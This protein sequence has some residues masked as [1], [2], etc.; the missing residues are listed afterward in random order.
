[1]NEE[2]LFTKQR[3]ESE[4]RRRIESKLDLAKLLKGEV[5]GTKN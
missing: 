5:D 4:A 2:P 3:K 1:M